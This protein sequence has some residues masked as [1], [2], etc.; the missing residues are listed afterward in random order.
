MPDFQTDLDISD[1]QIEGFLSENNTKEQ[2]ESKHLNFD[3]VRRS[4]LR[5]F[6]DM[7]ACPGSGKTTLVAS[8]LLMLAKEWHTKHQGIC[9]LTHTNVACDEIVSRLKSHPSG[10]KLTLYPHFIGTIQEFTNKY[11]AL[12]YVR[13]NDLPISRI[14][15]E[16][17]ERYMRRAVS[18][19]TLKYLERK[20]AFLLDLKIDHVTCEI[21]IPGFTA[22]SSSNSYNEM[23]T[24]L[25][26]RLDKG[27]FFYSEMYYFA[28]KAI[29]EN[30]ALIAALRKR[31]PFVILDEMQDTQKHQDE[32]INSIFE[33]ENVKLQ[34]FGDPDQAIFDNMGGD[35]PNQTF[36]NNGE[37][38]RVA[39]T[40]RFTQDIASKV[41]GLSFSQI[42]EVV[43][44]DNPARPYPHTIF[45]FD[46]LTKTN[47]LDNFSDL[48]SACDPDVNWTTVK[49]VGGTEGQ[50]RHISAYW[51]DFNRNRSVR[52]PRPQAL[53][54]IVCREWRQHEGHSERQYG[55]LIQTAVDLLR[56]SQ[57]MDVRFEPARDFTIPSLKS[58]LIENGKF[59]DFRS[60]LTSW[61]TDGMLDEDAWNA[62][63][64]KLRTLIGITSTTDETNRF[65][66]FSEAKPGE[67]ITA[68]TN[69]Y[70]ASNGRKIEVG[71]I[72]S[73]K[74][75]T[76]D[77]TLVLETK[78]HQNDLEQL[79]DHI[80]G[81][82]HQAISGVRKIK[83]A[84]LLYVATTRPRHL[85]CL[86]I[87]NE[88]ISEA[89]ET[90]LRKN[91]WDIKRLKPKIE[92]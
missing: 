39:T 84:R 44:R 17:C 35:E 46:D 54:E 77:A 20:H 36:N 82:N 74:G 76:H 66:S 33:H 73:V 50:G 81:I 71:T 9:V 58:F 31:F 4:A 65:L 28:K 8:K 15:D 49:A 29:V 7:Q 13:S 45:V 67:L 23:Q 30:E 2:D 53:S 22:V 61:I 42:G 85:L 26:E 63:V 24:A 14:D 55:I 64:L 72:H 91:G 83:F 86:A 69:T 38:E 16:V 88:N 32:L 90:A 70:E 80:S 5:S 10:V 59:A 60:M 68:K 3:E 40:H 41:K 78:N 37:L 87:H 48:V 79:L 12:P 43:A 11:L 27:L 25:K 56:I 21:N 51:D 89:Q 1:A 62:Q 6:D 52:T 57:T 47:V 75:E 92:S 34:R 18:R 19:S